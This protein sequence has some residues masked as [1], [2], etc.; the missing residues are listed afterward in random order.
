[1]QI[2]DG[3][4]SVS[5]NQASLF[6]VLTR[7]ADHG[8]FE[9][10]LA[11]P[12]HDA[13]VSERFAS[14]P[15][16]EAIER[17]L[18]GHSYVLTMAPDTHVPRPA[19]LKVL[20]VNAAAPRT[21]QPAAV[22]PDVTELLQGIEP[23]SLPAGMYDNLLTLSRPPDEALAER[24]TALRETLIERLLER[25]EAGHDSASVE[26]MRRLLLTTDGSDELDAAAG[27]VD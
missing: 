5:L 7:L 11:A 16:P 6:D 22:A 3:A 12:A 27:V 25:L 8:G 26:R 9:L 20:G 14:V 2:E 1:M 21:F 15:V 10:E 4:V 24:V 17:L 13:Q 18:R 23:E 19:S